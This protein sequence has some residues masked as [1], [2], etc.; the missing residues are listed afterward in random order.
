M[1]D[2]FEISTVLTASPHKVFAA[3]LDSEEH[4]AFIGAEA[5]I[6]PRVGGPFSAWGEYIAGKTLEL[7]KD[8]RIVQAWRTVD[9]PA[10][11]P[12]SRLEILLDKVEGGTRLTLIHR[13]IPDGMGEEYQQGWIDNYFEP[14]QR[15]FSG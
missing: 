13:E 15:Y 11:S 3:W 5:N 10:D 2:E 1:A 12:D 9:F 14:M 8:R 4:S 6:E 7:E